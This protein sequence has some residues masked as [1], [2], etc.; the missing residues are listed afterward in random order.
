[1]TARAALRELRRHMAVLYP[2]AP[3]SSSSRP[4]L[5]L[6][7]RPIFSQ[8]DRAQVAAWKAYLK[9]EESNPLEYEDKNALFTRVQGAYKKA[10]IKMRFFPEIWYALFFCVYIT[11]AHQ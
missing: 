6:P 9:W 3:N 7:Q 8:N 1:M 10:V 4:A 11:L 2:P 5:Q